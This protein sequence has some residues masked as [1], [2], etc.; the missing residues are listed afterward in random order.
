MA[1]KV[2]FGVNKV[3]FGAKRIIAIWLPSRILGGIHKVVFGS[4][5]VVFVANKIVAILHRFST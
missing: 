5:K 4:N 1:Y 3:A 2:V